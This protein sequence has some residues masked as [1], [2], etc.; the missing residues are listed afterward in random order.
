MGDTLGK[1]ILQ[2]MESSFL[3]VD[4]AQIVRHKADEPEATA[5]FL[6]ADSLAGQGDAEID[7]LA[8]EADSAATVRAVKTDSALVRFT[9]KGREPN[10]CNPL[11]SGTSIQAHRQSG[12]IDWTQDGPEVVGLRGELQNFTRN[13]G[14][15]SPSI[16]NYRRR[17][18]IQR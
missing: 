4:I 18:S 6:E 1:G 16:S 5:D 7:P 3:Q 14:L 12:L 11:Q 15:L 8:I 13:S 9:T 10:V 17:E 2:G